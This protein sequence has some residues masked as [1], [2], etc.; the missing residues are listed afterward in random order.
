[1]SSQH[2]FMLYVG[3]VAQGRAFMDLALARG[4]WVYLA[5]DASEALGAFLA[6]T[7]D[8]VILD[9]TACPTCAA[10]VYHHLRSIRAQ[11]LFVLTLDR[12][13]DVSAREDDLVYLLDPATPPDDLL[14]YVRAALAPLDAPAA[15][16]Y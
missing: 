5:E 6:Y 16:L 10:E 13:W 2:P 3:G 1:M 15:F 14:E 4:S 8:A 7:P 11:P 9:P 12:D